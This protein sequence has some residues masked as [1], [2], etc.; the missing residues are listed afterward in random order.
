MDCYIN[1]SG[2]N[3]YSIESK[4]DEV[5]N[6]PSSRF[7]RPYNRRFKL[8]EPLKLK[9]IKRSMTYAAK[10][11]EI[12]HLWWHPHNYGANLDENF[13]FLDEILS[14]FSRLEK[15]YGF[16]SYTMSQVADESNS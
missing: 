8:L 6:I 5:V 15:E 3:T 4:G 9:R 16:K 11:G 13:A 12:F 10:K 1:L 7:L 14:H 2:H